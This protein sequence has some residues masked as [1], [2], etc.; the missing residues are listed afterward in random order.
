MN[1]QLTHIRNA[2]RRFA[3]RGRVARRLEAAVMVVIVLNVLVLM[4]DSV[5]DIHR[6]HDRLLN[7]LEW[8]FTTLFT[9][10]YLVRLWLLRRPWLYA[11]SFFGV[12]DLLSIL[13]VFL[14]L[15]LPGLHVLADVRLLRLLRL[16][17]ILQLPVYLEETR[18]LRHA[19]ARARRK[20]LVFIGVM[21]LLIMLLGTVIFLVEGP[22]NGFS[23]IPVGVYW[24]AVTMSTTGYGDIT[25]QTGLGRL[26]TACAI[27]LGYGIIAFPTGIMGAELFA[28][29]MQARQPA[30]DTCCCSCHGDGRGALPPSSATSAPQAAS[31]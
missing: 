8:T 15:L 4:L 3:E 10:E 28:G 13:P 1:S 9:A 21:V 30:P 27:L 18:H 20:I 16:F 2:A 29:A 31:H 24:A 22:G 11:R 25:P 17:R 5:A 6:Q 26:I 14:A 19:L 23:S 7:T 12:V